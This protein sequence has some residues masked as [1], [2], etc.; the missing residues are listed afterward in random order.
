MTL[1]KKLPKVETVEEKNLMI[2]VYF[3]IQSNDTRE[4]KPK[5]R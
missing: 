1:S 4:L 2:L 3:T 5:I